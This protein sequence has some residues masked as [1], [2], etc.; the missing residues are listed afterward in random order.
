MT[1]QSTFNDRTTY[2]LGT[3]LGVVLTAYFIWSFWVHDFANHAAF[4]IGSIS[5][6]V[7]ALGC[8]LCFGI[9]LLVYASTVLRHAAFVIFGLGTLLGTANLTNLLAPQLIAWHPT[10]QHLT[11][12][13]IERASG[14]NGSI[15]PDALYA[16]APELCSDLESLML[17]GLS[18]DAAVRALNQS[19]A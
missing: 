3:L 1:T 12:C 15:A 5:G 6:L 7:L 16:R 17:S 13:G 19:R 8:T 9:A 11:F 4:S 10:G 14:R 18:G 2:I